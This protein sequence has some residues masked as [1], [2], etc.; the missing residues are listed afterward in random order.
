[1]LSAVRRF[2]K[3]CAFRRFSTKEEE[4]DSIDTIDS[5]DALV[6]RKKFERPDRL[7]VLPVPK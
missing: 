6:D 5:I 1:M 4:S 2:W 3:P 7:F